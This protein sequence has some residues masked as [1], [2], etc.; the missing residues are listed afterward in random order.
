MQYNKVIIAGNLGSDP[1][2][3]QREDGRSFCT[4]RLFVNRTF[5]TRDNATGELTKNE[6]VDCPVIQCWGKN[7]E[8]MGKYLTKGRNVLIEGHIETHQWQD[9]NDP[10]VTHN[11]TVV[12]ADDFKFIDKPRTD[13]ATTPTDE[14]T[15]K[16][17]SSEVES[18]AVDI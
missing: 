17:N 11:E 4:F 9:K 1:F 10:N 15:P 8:R 18:V 12:M 16:D 7:A 14:T 5:F 2:F 13:R 3:K 6:S